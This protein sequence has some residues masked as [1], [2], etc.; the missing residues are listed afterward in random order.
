MAVDGVATGAT[1]DGRVPATAT[2][3]PSGIVAPLSTQCVELRVDSPGFRLFG[4]HL[5]DDLISYLA[6]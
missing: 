3:M 6:W 1:P 4:D 5:V 2:P